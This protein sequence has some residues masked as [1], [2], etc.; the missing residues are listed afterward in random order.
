MTINRDIIE[1]WGQHMSPEEIADRLNI[2]IFQ[3]QHVIESFLDD[4]TVN[5]D[6]PKEEA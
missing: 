5:W 2:P 6:T 1:L 3:V 4:V